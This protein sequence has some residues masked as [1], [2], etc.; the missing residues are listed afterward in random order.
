MR[1]TGVTTEYSCKR[2][3]LLPVLG[4]Q[5]SSCRLQ[6]TDISAQVEINKAICP[7]LAD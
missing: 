7:H 6:R 2:S 1:S 4:L 5:L 3:G